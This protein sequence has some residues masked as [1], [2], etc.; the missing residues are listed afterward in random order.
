MRLIATITTTTMII[1]CSST[2]NELARKFA[3]FVNVSKVDVSHFSR[4][5]RREKG[6]VWDRETKRK[7]HRWYLRVIHQS[8]QCRLS[9]LHPPT[10]LASIG[11]CFCCVPHLWCGPLTIEK[12]NSNVSCDGYSY[13]WYIQ[14]VTFSSVFEILSPL[15]VL[16]SERPR[17]RSSL[18]YFENTWSRSKQHGEMR[19]EKF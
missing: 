13:T 16:S 17:V 10:T 7:D 14:S 9:K 11:R 6:R 2:N 8:T 19:H 15:F 4:E 5:W 18:W 12:R 1:T 3:I